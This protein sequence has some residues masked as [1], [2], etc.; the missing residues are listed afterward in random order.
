[1][2][3]YPLSKLMFR[4]VAVLLVIGDVMLTASKN[5]G[6]IKYTFWPGLGNRP[7]VEKRV[8]DAMAPESSLPGRPAREALKR[9]G[10]SVAFVNTST[11]WKDAGKCV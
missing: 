5:G 1:M 9:E 2:F 7:M 11:G 4:I 3:L 6:V 10:M 8:K